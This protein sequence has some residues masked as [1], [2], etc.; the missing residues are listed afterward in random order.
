[1]T[2]RAGLVLTV[3]AVG[4]ALLRGH[5]QTPPAQTFRTGI[6][7]VIVDVS[8]R[9]HS[10]AVTGLRAEDFVLT[11]NGVRQRIES[12][13]ATAVPIDLTLVVDLSGNPAGV[14]NTRPS[15]ART[16]AA[17]QAEVSEVAKMLRPDDRIRLLAIDTRVQ[18]VWAMQPVAS[19]PAIT[20]LE[21]DG[22][23]ALYDT[24]AAAL[25]Q[26]VEPAR[27]HVVIARTKGLDTIS[28]IDAGAVRAIAERSDALL[29]VVAMETALDNDMALRGF[30]CQFMGFCWPTRRSW[31]P[32][33]HRLF[34]PVHQ[35]LPDGEALAG[36][37]EATGGVL[38]KAAMLSVPTLTSTFRTVFDDFR[39]SYVLRYTPREVP[40]GGWHTIEVRVPGFRSYIVRSRRGY[41]VEEPAPAPA[42]AVIPKI[43]RTLGELTTAYGRE[44]YRQVMAGL[45]EA[46]DPERLLRDFERAGNP[47]PAAPRREA[48]FALEV[49]EPAIFST[50]R[51]TRE[52]VYEFLSRFSRLVRHPL[53]PDLFERYWHFTL[54]TLL[55][56]SIRPAA[57]EAFVERAL[58]RFPDEPRFVLSRA[59]V[60]DQRWATR[61]EGPV[62]GADGLPT[63][64]HV[65]AVRSRYAAAI[66]LRDTAIEA[67]IRLA[68]FLHRIERH[69]D[70][71]AHLSA[72]GAQ[73][74]ADPTLRYLR[75]LFLGHVLGALGRHDEAMEAYRGA[76][77]VVPG[78][79]SPRVAL[80]NALVMRGD[81]AG[82]EALAQQVQ[83]DASDDLDPWWMYWQ[84][85]YRLNSLAMTRLRELSR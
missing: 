23:A 31:T 15:L 66:A 46:R 5:A 55:E 49:A 8:V 21:I 20:R 12:V 7:L 42:P 73:P 41:L 58:E 9:D 3:L 39:S 51:E 26:P 16:T 19:L 54:L 10:R 84:G 40:A 78:A 57:A 28:S 47:W 30:Q 11:D 67:N 71:L 60:T 24:L 13:E 2:G 35:M 37:A 50:R 48:A 76:L 82:A 62:T 79:Q 34:G 59:I 18:Q 43:P 80:M 38:H 6:E 61:V 4:A 29:H 14:W 74:I 27:R 17:I 72:G 45:R 1:M 77:G 75:Q 33:E 56:G 64:A 81:H 53:E 52:T 83:L 44:A 22:M 36:G 70:A 85:Q 63:P 65:E 69:D 25:L 32:F 68:W